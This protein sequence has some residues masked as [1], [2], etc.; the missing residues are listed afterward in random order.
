MSC[1]YSE[2]IVEDIKSFARGQAILVVFDDLIGSNSLPEIANMFTVDARHLNISMVFLSQR[3]FVNDEYFRQISQNCDYFCLFKNPRN[4]SEI[5]TLAQQM[6]PGNMV[7]V[8]IY[9][10]ATERPFTYLFINLNQECDAEVKY[11][12]NFFDGTIYVYVNVGRSFKKMVAHGSFNSIRL[13]QESMEKNI[14]LKPFNLSGSQMMY[15]NNVYP[16]W[17]TQH[18]NIYLQPMQTTNENCLSCQEEENDIYTESIMKQETNGNQY[19]QTSNPVNS[20]TGTNT[21]LPAN[22]FTQTSRPRSSS[23]ATGTD[24]LHDRQIQTLY[25]QQNSMG[26]ETS[27]STDRNVQTNEIRSVDNSTGMASSIMGT[28]T[29]Q[30]R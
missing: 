1:I 29:P 10:D 6:M 4:S 9:Q 17:Q 12:S 25:P 5:R 26:T 23:V 21:L 3:M 18:Q 22:Q 20:V 27:M 2:N 19:V 8:D 14:T 28:Q 16:N 30:Y 11:L 7:L 24:M 13:L 15:E